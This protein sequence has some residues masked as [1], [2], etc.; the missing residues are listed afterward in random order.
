MISGSR[1]VTPDDTIRGVAHHD[2]GRGA[3]VERAAVACGHLAVG[4]ESRLELRQLLDG[5]AGPG[6]VVDA[7]LGAIS[8]DERADLPIEEPVVLGRHGALLGAGREG[9]HVLPADVLELPHV[10]RGLSHGD[11]DVR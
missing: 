10:L 9:V 5:R 8:Q 3:V 4:A 2:H 7:D 1:A 11:V 6:P